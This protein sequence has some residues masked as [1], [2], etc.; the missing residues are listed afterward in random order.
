MYNSH[1]FKKALSLKIFIMTGVWSNASY[2]PIEY[3]M[4]L[5]S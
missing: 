2:M 5:V 4:S 3:Y 1:F